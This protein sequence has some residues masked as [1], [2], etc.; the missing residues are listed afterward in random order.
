MSIGEI[1]LIAFALA[2]DAFAVSVACGLTARKVHLHHALST[3]VFFGGFQALMP[4]IGWLLGRWAAT[5]IQAWDH[6]VAFALLGAIGGK[7]LYEALFPDKEEEEP[8]NPFRFSNLLLMAISTS[9]DALAVGIT[10]SLLNVSLVTPVIVI[11]VITGILSFSGTYIGMFFG[12]LFERKLEI[13]GGL[14]LIGI[15]VKILFEHLLG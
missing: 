9:I 11:G 15:G 6:W 8:K 7:M 13:A 14:V 3:G 5:Y 1:I 10:L 12:H 4:V 2:A